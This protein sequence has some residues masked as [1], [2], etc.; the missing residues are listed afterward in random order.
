MSRVLV[1]GDR[2]FIDWPTMVAVLQRHVTCDDVLIQGECIGADRMA[3][4]IGR[5][6]IGCEVEGFPANWD[7][8]GKAAGPIRNRQIL[9]TKPDLV[10]A[11]HYNYKQSRGTKDCVE[12]AMRRGINVILVA[13]RDKDTTR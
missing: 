6:Q 13:E 10:I 5:T 2:R 8:Y 11:F 12:Q 7:K 1:C 9:D 3:A 4:Q